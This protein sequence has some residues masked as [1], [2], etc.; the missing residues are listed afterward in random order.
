MNYMD[1]LKTKIARVLAEYPRA[2]DDDNFLI[3][4]IYRNYYNVAATSFFEVM[5]N[6]NGLELPK[7]ESITRIRRMLQREAP[8]LYGASGF[9][10]KERS[11]LEEEYREQYRR[12]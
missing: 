3:A 8:L 9:I 6:L 12:K 1:D 7:P 2:R 4:I 11:R 10:R 5:A